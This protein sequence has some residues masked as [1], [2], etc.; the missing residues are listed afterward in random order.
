M[1]VRRAGEAM[2]VGPTPLPQMPE[3]LRSLFEPEKEK[4]G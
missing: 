3:E 2:G 1:C 4:V